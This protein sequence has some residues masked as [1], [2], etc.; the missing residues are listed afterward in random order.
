MTRR[1]PAI[2]FFVDDLLSD[3]KVQM[4]GLEALGLWIRIL[5]VMHKDGEPYGH[6]RIG[7]RS[8]G[9][10]E[11]ARLFGESPKRIN[12]L[13]IA[14]RSTDV[15]SMTLDGTIFSRRLVRDEEIRLKRAAGG[16]KSLEN[17]NVPRPKPSVE[18]SGHGSTEGYPSVDPSGGPHRY[19]S[20]SSS[21]PSSV[22][23]SREEKK[24]GEN[25]HS[26][27]ND[28]SSPTLVKPSRKSLPVDEDF[29]NQLRANPAYT[30]I[31]DLVL[32]KLN[33]WLLGKGKGKKLT[34]ARLIDWLN[35]ERPPQLRNGNNRGGKQHDERIADKDFHRGW[36]RPVRAT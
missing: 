10:N 7:G 28:A 13:L 9:V 26:Q 1:T 31:L 17:P 27:T 21:S 14:L 15:F 8:F 16:I 34:R 2:L 29:L 19:P 32:N 30:D 6:L 18:G 23:Y 24:E 12:R 20:S 4:A 3:P 35:R 22:P 33:G 25:A 36:E 5:C 11:M